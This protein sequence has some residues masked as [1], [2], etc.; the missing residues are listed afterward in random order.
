MATPLLCETVTGQ[1][2][3]DL[4]AARDAS[5]ADMVEVRLDGVRD[6]DVA[7]IL[8]GRQRPMIVTCRPT[9]EGGRFDGSEEE[10]C[11]ILREALA[12]GAEFVDVEW[13]ALCRADQPAFEAAVDA[14]RARIVVS[15]HDFDGVPADLA[16]RVRD[17]R[18]RGPAVVKVAITP[19]TLTDTLVLVD[20]ARGGSAVVIGMGNAGVPT[21]LLAAHYG[22]RWSYAGNG[23]AP[24]Q[25]P[26]G[27]MLS[28]FRFRQIR[29]ETRIFG[30]VSSNAMHSFS[31]IM[32]NAALAAAGLDAVYIPLPTTDFSDFEAFASALRVEG[33]SV[34]IPF[35][36][37]AL[38]SAA[39]TDGLTRL[40]GAANTLKR[41]DAGW[42]AANTDVAGFLAP[43][44]DAFGG[45]LA[46]ARAAV[47]GGG[48]AARAAVVALLSQG[49]GV[50]V[51]TRRGE[52]AHEVTNALGVAA[53][54]WPVPPGWDLLVNCTPLGGPPLRNE[55]PLP[56]G[57]F[58]GR[59]V[60]DLTYGAGES[61]LVR[62]APAAGCRTTEGLPMRVAHAERQYKWWTG[63]LPA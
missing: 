31:P 13:A 25:I 14:E 10:R 12:L 55:S 28:Q 49:A 48:G 54:A 63:A 3:A 41:S 22:S 21:R 24:G 29:P 35:K 38:R 43:L 36:G 30:V 5:L 56:G 34:T 51:H 62:E 18:S 1:S 32:H 4:R 17:M 23:V 47:V 33:V 16:E 42:A 46:G 6:V 11:A 7:G 8:T 9:W 27:R 53:G 45:P 20:I 40:V 37:D 60:Y 57:P 15:S 2:M 19:R 39:T 52:Q 58:T 50:T 59:L 26:A 61:R 44:P